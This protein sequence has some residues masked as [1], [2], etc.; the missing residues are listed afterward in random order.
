[1]FR[2]KRPEL[3]AEIWELSKGGS[4]VLTGSPGVGKSW[5][6]A[7]LI[8]QC[9]SESRPYLPIAAEDFE[10]SSID[11]LSSALKFK[12]DILFL[13]ASFGDLADASD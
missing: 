1:M 11:E 3:T 13:L 5:I 12:S 4:V 10:V 7:Q 8:R 6:I 9:R 2:I